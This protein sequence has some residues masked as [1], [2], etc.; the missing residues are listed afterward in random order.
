MAALDP[1]VNGGEY[2]GPDGFMEAKGSPCKV[3]STGRS[4][5]VSVAQKLWQESERLTGQEFIV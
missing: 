5:N 4:H 1:S 2:Y 3:K